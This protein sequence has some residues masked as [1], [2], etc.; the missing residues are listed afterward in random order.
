MLGFGRIVDTA[1]AQ[2]VI[3]T[4]VALAMPQTDLRMT[5]QARLDVE[6]ALQGMSDADLALTYA[7]IFA[8][9][10]DYIGED[11]LSV[12]RALVDYALLTEAALEARGIPRPSG[13][14]SARSMLTTY[15][16]AL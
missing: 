1:Q 15:E 3:E 14:E 2:T 12:A 9:F 5:A 16:L 7:R 4:P 8:T 10:R 13:T 11:D 6:S